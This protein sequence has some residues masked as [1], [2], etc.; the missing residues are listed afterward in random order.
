MYTVSH[1]ALDPAWVQSALMTSQFERPRAPRNWTPLSW[2]SEARFS[3][4]GAG[5]IK[6][7]VDQMANRHKGY[8]LDRWWLNVTA[9]GLD[10]G[11][12]QHGTNMISMVYYLQVPPMSG[13]IELLDPATDTWVEYEPRAGDLLEFDGMIHHRVKK[14]LSDDIRISLALNVIDQQT[15]RKDAM[16]NRSKLTKL[17]ADISIEDAYP[18]VN[19]TRHR[20]T[21]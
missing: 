15:A 18:L 9:P 16:I 20:G 14:N 13:N 3:T 6:P 10:F 19:S 8:T 11:Q 17:P 1:I 5:I 12:H 7:L 21:M 4:L 2:H